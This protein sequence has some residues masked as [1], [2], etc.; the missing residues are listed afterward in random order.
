MHIRKAW[1][2]LRSRIKEWGWEKT[3]AVAGI[4]LA[5]VGIVIT[6][7]VMFIQP[8]ITQERIVTGL[9]WAKSQWIGISIAVVIS[10]VVLIALKQQLDKRKLRREMEALSKKSKLEIDALAEKS[11]LELEALS[12]KIDKQEERKFVR[13]EAINTI[14][15]GHI[16]YYPLVYYVFGDDMPRGIGIRLIEQ[17]FGEGVISKHPKRGRWDDL[18]E[19]L[20]RGEYDIVATPLYETQSRSKLVSFCSPIFFSDIG[21]YVKKDGKWFKGR[22]KNSLKFGEATEILRNLRDLKLTAIE[23]ELSG[24]MILKHLQVEKSKVNWLGR[25]EASVS[26]LIGSLESKEMPSDVVFAEV[27]QA[28]LT[29]P[30]KSGSVINL[31]ENKQLLYPVSFAIRKQEYVLRH[32]INLKLAEIDEEYPGGILG[33]ILDELKK[34]PDFQ[35]FDL[36]QIRRYFVREKPERMM[37]P[38]SALTA[39]SN[40]KKRRP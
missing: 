33:F 35:G 29:N 11:R 19:K 30:V 24:K 32:F 15:Y 10:V 7:L 23:G 3:L 17:I 5:V 2:Q 20:S 28:E 36:D 18:V 39:H 4:A 34:H 27:F 6:V 37:L 22:E 12:A 9:E 21:I 14:V 38:S 40:G 25:D 1:D 13:F 8:F 16:E 26:G 31:L